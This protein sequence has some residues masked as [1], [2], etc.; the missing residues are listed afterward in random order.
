MVNKNTR[1]RVMLSLL[2]T[3]CV[4]SNL[5]S[6]GLLD[7]LYTTT[8]KAFTGED[9]ET[10]STTFYKDFFG[11][12]ISTLYYVETPY[13]NYSIDIYSNWDQSSTSTYLT[14]EE[15][16]TGTNSIGTHATV[17][18]VVTPQSDDI[19]VVTTY[20][21]YTTTTTY[22]TSYNLVSTTVGLDS[23]GLSAFGLSSEV[24]STS[25]TY[26][27]ATLFPSSIMF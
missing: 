11:N 6:A 25:T 18:Y 24:T 10:Y 23:V 15:Y 20:G 1:S 13:S 17:Y 12:T 4:F 14:Q 26:Y 16:Y 9:T 2:L 19:S 27:V 8:A 22:S 5:V 3:S 7:G 21:D